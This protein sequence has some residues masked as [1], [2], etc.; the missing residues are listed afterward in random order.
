MG[1]T[2]YKY[3]GSHAVWAL[4]QDLM[5]THQ[6]L[7]FHM[8][9]VL[10]CRQYVLAP[11]TQGLVLVFL[12]LGLDICCIVHPPPTPTTTTDSSKIMGLSSYG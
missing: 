11:E 2:G 9:K 10:C 12:P 5:I 3:L 6:E 4:H 8:H 7:F 1:S